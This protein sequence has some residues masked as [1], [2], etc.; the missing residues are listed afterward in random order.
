M[1]RNNRES[2]DSEVK[3]VFETTDHASAHAAMEATCIL[4]D[5][6][7]SQLKAATENKKKQSC[8]RLGL[9]P[10]RCVQTYRR[11]NVASISSSRVSLV[12]EPFPPETETNGPQNK[13]T[14]LSQWL[15]LYESCPCHS[16]STWNPTSRWS[17]SPPRHNMCR[18]YPG[19][20]DAV[21]VHGNSPRSAIV[22]APSDLPHA[23]GVSMFG[24]K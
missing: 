12:E 11:P 8:I 6:Y 16:A 21:R 18:T 3:L 10:D 19:T 13:F 24:Y 20:E 15:S 2:G 7:D 23:Y 14:G 9:S 4:I 22:R 5:T 17:F 1:R